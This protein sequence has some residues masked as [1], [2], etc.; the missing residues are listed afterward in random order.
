MPSENSA[1]LV[2]PVLPQTFFSS[3]AAE[4]PSFLAHTSCAPFLQF[5]KATTSH[6]YDGK[7]WAQDT[8]KCVR[9]R[10]E[11]EKENYEPFSGPAKNVAVRIDLSAGS[12]TIEKSRKGF[13]SAFD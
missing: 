10:G 4:F 13:S 8:V 6:G 11:K 5:L 1:T 7:K 9:E 2:F 3:S 12:L